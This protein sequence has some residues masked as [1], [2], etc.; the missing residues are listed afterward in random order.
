MK[1][2]V[3]WIVALI[4]VVTPLFVLQQLPVHPIK[5]GPHSPG[6][7][8][9]QLKG[10]PWIS[11]TALVTVDAKGALVWGT[12][13]QSTETDHSINLL[14]CAVVG[15]LAS[16]SLAC[17]L[18]PRFPRY[19]ILSLLMIVTATSI[20]IMLYSW[21]LSVFGKF[22]VLIGDNPMEVSN[23]DRPVFHN[24]I[25]LTL[26]SLAIYFPLE[27]AYLLFRRGTQTAAE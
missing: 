17:Y 16:A 22:N 3:L 26:V 12:A 1:H 21:D 25:A 23:S 27:S 15:T 10:W 7:G 18:F 20:A 11:E 24:A 5:D 8:Y 19:S 6:S 2:V 4:I 9:L 13:H 14:V